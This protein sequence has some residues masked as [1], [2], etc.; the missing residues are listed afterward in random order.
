M[1]SNLQIHRQ[2]PLSNAKISKETKITLYKL[3]QKYDAIILKH[4]NDI[5]QTDLIEVHI[6]TRQDA[7]PVAA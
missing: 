4:S 5:G 7:A 3:L 6:A 1:P 2:V